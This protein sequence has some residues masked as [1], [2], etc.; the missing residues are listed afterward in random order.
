MARPDYEPHPNVTSLFSYPAFQAIA[1]RLPGLDASISRLIAEDPGAASLYLHYKA[2]EA[3]KV[4]ANEDPRVSIRYDGLQVHDDDDDGGLALD[5]LAFYVTIGNVKH[6]L[7]RSQCQ[8]DDDLPGHII[9]PKWLA[10]KEG[11]TSKEK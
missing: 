5:P 1:T 10:E 2:H 6:V 11:L 3:R 8:L 4:F 7:P 9:M